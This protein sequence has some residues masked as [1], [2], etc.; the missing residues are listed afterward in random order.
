MSV[1]CFSP[2][3]ISFWGVRPKSIP[4]NISNDLQTKETYWDGPSSGNL[5]INLFIY[6]ATVLAPLAAIIERNDFFS[7]RHHL[8][9][10]S[11]RLKQ[12]ATTGFN[13]LWQKQLDVAKFN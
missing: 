11:L 4:K 2:I 8:F 10:P 9:F 5:I 13:Y 12:P 7:H 6:C 1:V 3:V